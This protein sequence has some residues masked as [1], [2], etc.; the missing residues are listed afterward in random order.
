[1]TE[2]RVLV[3]GDGNLTFAHALL[4]RHN[5]PR[6]AVKRARETDQA[7]KHAMPSYS[8]IQLTASCFDSVEECHRKYPESRAITRKLIDRGADV[9]FNIDA[10]QL[11]NMTDEL[12]ASLKSSSSSELATD[13]TKPS[14][15]DW[16]IFNGP[17]LGFESVEAHRSLMRHI[18]HSVRSVLK[19]GG[20]FDVTLCNDQPTLWLVES[21]ALQFN[22]TIEQVIDWQSEFEEWHAMGYECRRHQS[23]KRF[24]AGAVDKRFKYIF[25]RQMTDVEEMQPSSTENQCPICEVTYES[26]TALQDHLNGVQPVDPALL[27][28]QCP[29]CRRILPNPRALEQHL[30]VMA[31]RADHVPLVEPNAG[32][33]TRS[34]LLESAGL[35]SD[36]KRKALELKRSQKIKADSATDAME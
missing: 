31:Q 13:D 36:E 33:V 19:P 26:L 15:F 16:V 34:K 6:R 12:T 22:W 10:T 8:R 3:L 11:H 14:L 2:R 25:K 1:M 17:H 7:T 20:R 9:R 27:N 18:F 24:D 28:T 35:L 29:Q 4:M 21:A 23:G 5:P 32:K 30:V